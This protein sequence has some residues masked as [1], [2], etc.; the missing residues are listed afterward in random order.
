MERVPR[1]VELDPL[2]APEIG[3]DDD[4]FR[5]AVAVEEEDLERV[6]EIVVVELAVPDAM[7]P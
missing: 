5:L 4:V 3:T 6:A 1:D 2:S 7:G